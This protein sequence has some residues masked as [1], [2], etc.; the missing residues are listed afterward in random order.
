MYRINQ[1]NLIIIILVIIITSILIL[2]PKHSP[3]EEPQEFTLT[4]PSTHPSELT[5]EHYIE[6]Y[7]YLCNMIETN[8][9][10]LSLKNRTHHIYWLDRRPTTIA[11]LQ[12]CT[13]NLDFLAI[14]AKEITA[15]QNRHTHLLTP[16][17][18][19]EYYKTYADISFMAQVFSEEVAKANQYWQPYYFDYYYSSNTRYP[20]EII[21]DRG[22]YVIVN[23]Q[24]SATTQYGYNLTLTHINY[25]QVH[26]AI[27]T[28]NTYIDHDPIQSQPYI[29]TITPTL[30][31]DA[32]LTIQ[33]P[34]GSQS[35]ITLPTIYGTARTN[36]YPLSNLIT[37][38]YPNNSTAYIYVKTFDPPTIQEL[39]PKIHQFLQE[40]RDYEYLIIDIRGNTGGAFQ[41]W[42]D[43]IVCPIIKEPT[44]HEYYLGYR[45]DSYIKSFH[46]RWLKDKEPV[47]KD[48]FSML[49]PEIKT[50]D[51]SIYN[52]ST[53]YHPKNTINNTATRIILTDRTVYSAAEGFTNFCKQTGFATIIGTTT[54]GDGFFSWPVYIVL[55]HSK[56][57]ITMTSSMSL[58]QK[59]RANEEARTTPD[60]I[61]ETSITDHQELIEYTIQLIKE[62]P[63][64]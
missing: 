7:Q 19:Q 43:A 37:R 23:Q 47:P 31:P 25:I 30:F 14:I 10:Y 36:F 12:N 1:R 39:I 18:V 48:Y 54:G 29:W 5:T 64:T 21:Y 20:I 61:H 26:E 2:K 9:P 6:D 35:I 38:T 24:G 49:P 45:E 50:P 62:I 59:G 41:S 63:I 8:Y 15:L 52:S 51:Y 40:T 42:L 53:T 11:L 55:P 3:I 44:L 56:L 60:I 4:L 46:N 34:N 32:D 33:H 27:R 16:T 28:A 57:V 22:N 17:E 58:D 13:S